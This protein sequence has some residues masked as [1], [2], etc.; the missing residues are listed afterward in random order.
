[1][2]TILAQCHANVNNMDANGWSPLHH[3][4]YIGDLEVASI[5]LENGANVN[6]FSN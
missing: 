3:A 4:A 1:V 2:E 6:A 5:L